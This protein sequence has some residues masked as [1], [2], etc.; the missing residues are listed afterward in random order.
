MNAVQSALSSQRLGR[1]FFWISVA[2]LA[3]GLVVLIV[4]LA[5][6]GST[7][8]AEPSK[9]AQTPAPV[10]SQGLPASTIHHYSQVDPA[11]KLAIRKFILGAVTRNDLRSAWRYVAPGSDLRKGYSLKAWAK[12][13]NPVIPFPVY[14][15]DKSN[16]D[17][18]YGTPKRLMIDVALVATPKSKLRPT[19]FR[20]GLEKVGTG[21]N[22]HWL[23]NYWFP[24]YTPPIPN[25]EQ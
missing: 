1:I 18:V 8:A 19:T 21:N 6:R 24:R 16:Y 17:V 5:D 4:K 11:A 15:F 7:P 12:G 25:N 23:V 9:P 10:K 13:D 20:I 22:S 14:E 3:A 2:V